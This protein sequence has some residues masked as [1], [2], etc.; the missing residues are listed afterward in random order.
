MKN[1]Y[2]IH[3]GENFVFAII[4]RGQ[5]GSPVVFESRNRSE[6]HEKLD[7]LSFAQSERRPESGKLASRAAPSPSPHTLG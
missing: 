4:D 6:A 5:L 7:Q 3:R 2:V 1:R